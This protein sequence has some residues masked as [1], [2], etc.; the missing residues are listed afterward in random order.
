MSENNPIQYHA[1]GSCRT[2]FFTDAE[3]FAHPCMAKKGALRPAELVANAPYKEMKDVKN[4]SSSMKDESKS[5]N[6]PDAI[7]DDESRV[8]A[9]RELM[10]MKEELVAAGIECQTLDEA[11]TKSEYERYKATVTAADNTPETVT[12]KTKRG[13]K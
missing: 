11:A 7:A 13:K 12:V 1:C 3:F 4:M 2:E 10:K 8:L 6:A 9:A 5:D